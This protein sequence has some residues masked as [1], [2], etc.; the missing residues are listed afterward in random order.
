MILIDTAE[1]KE[2]ERLISQ[3]VPVSRIGL[4][5]RLGLTTT[6]VVRMAEHVSSVGYRLT[7]CC[8]MWIVR[9]MSYEDT[10]SLQMSQI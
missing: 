7:S 6:L 1:P 9:K 3:A 5:F 4:I 2:L 8:L 10:T